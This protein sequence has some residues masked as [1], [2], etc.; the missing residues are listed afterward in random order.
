[1]FLKNSQFSFKIRFD[2]TCFLYCVGLLIFHIS[3]MFNYLSRL[4][5]VI[6]RLL[7]YSNAALLGAGASLLS[8]ASDI[9]GSARLPAMFC[10]VFGHKPTPNWVSVE[11]HKPGAGDKN[12]SSFFAIG[13]MVRYAS[14]LS[15][16]L[17]VMSQTDKARIG[18]NKKVRLEDMKFFYMDH[19][20]SSVTSSVNSDI[21]GV[22]Y[23]LIRY[24]ETTYNVKVQK[25]Y[26]EDMKSSLELCGF[27]LLKIQD[28]YSMFNRS[29][30]PKKSK[31]VF[32]ETLKY[33]FFMSSHTFP[34]ICYGIIKNICERLPVSKYNKLLETRMRLKKQFEELLGDNGILIFPSFISPA[35]YPHES[36]YNVCN[37][38]YM[39]IFNVLGFPVT[40]C[41]LGFDK[42]QLPIG[43]QIVANPGCD[44]LTIAVAQEIERI[45]GGWR[46][47]SESKGLTYT[48]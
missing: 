37:Y 45:F 17:T 47:P 12:W 34:A 10:G 29:D 35:H 21:K 30:D 15:L 1:M 48:M 13:S 44:Y 43:L 24:L 32:I 16:I 5:H 28:V 41:P 26:L 25:A 22:I 36:L 6:L 11:G 4:Q 23:K 33:F 46:E 38:T 7:F 39:M 14:D 31:N 27:I 8:L 40:Q 9:G 19:C 2:K 20:G 42:N 18:F 3:E